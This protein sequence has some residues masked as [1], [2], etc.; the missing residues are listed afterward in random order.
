MK[1][2]KRIAVTILSMAAYAQVAYAAYTYHDFIRNVINVLLKPMVNILFL[3]AVLFF[4]WG[5]IEYI[6]GGDSETA[7]TTGRNHMLWGLVGL[8]IMSSV[9]FILTILYSVFYTVL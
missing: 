2:S 4:I 1:L 5:V 8:A 7:H 3:A 6:A 9:Y